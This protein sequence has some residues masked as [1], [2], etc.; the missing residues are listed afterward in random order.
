LI[1]LLI[2][3]YNRTPLLKKS[4]EALRGRTLPD[5]ILIVDDG[6]SDGCE[7]LCKRAKKW[8]RCPVRY[9]YTH[10]PFNSQCSHSRNVGVRNTKAD[11]IVT[12][13]PELIFVTD[14]IAEF[15]ELHR[16]H[17]NEVISAGTVHR[18]KED[19]SEGD[20]TVGWVAPFTALYG[21][22][23]LEAIGAWDEYGFPDTWSFDDT[24]LLTRLRLTGHGQIIAN[25]IEVLHQF[26]PTRWTRQD[27]NDAYFQSKGFDNGNREFIVANQGQPW[28]EIKRKP[29]NA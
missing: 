26:H 1:S 5:E 19:G 4:F 28:G 20:T 23:W 8:F 22:E 11:L 7:D 2:T 3:T 13:E 21:R 29:K 6:G 12:S 15:R 10:Q 27:R 25:E 18:L 14:V 24:D 9:I 16:L 17:P